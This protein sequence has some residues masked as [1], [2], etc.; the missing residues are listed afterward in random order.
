MLILKLTLLTNSLVGLFFE[1]IK[2][3]I[4]VQF[5]GPVLTSANINFS[6]WLSEQSAHLLL[7]VMPALMVFS[8]CAIL[9]GK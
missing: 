5:L 7:D 1:N 9:S 2:I 8:S 3:R 4:I 6:F